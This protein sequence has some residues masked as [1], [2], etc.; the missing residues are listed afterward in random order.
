MMWRTTT[1][2]NQG[3]K[4][5]ATTANTQQNVNTHHAEETLQ[6]DIRRRMYERIAQGHA[7]AEVEADGSQAWENH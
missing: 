7:I 6:A 1:K 3:F 5:S 2:V 4:G